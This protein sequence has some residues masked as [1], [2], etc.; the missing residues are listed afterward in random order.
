MMPSRSH[1]V[2]QAT[3]PQPGELSTIP[4]HEQRRE[5]R[6]PTKQRCFVWGPGGQGPEGWRCIAYNISRHGIGITLPLPLPAGKVIRIQP[7]QLPGAG[8]IEAQIVH[9]K[10]VEFL[11][12]AGCTLVEPMSEEALFRW[13]EAARKSQAD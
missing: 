9:S 13:L 3:K 5:T 1:P 4:L 8:L 10:R 12:F 6:F 2:S 11:W 7:Y